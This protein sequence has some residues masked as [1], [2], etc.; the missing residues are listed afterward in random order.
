MKNT[1]IKYFKNWGFILFILLILEIF[2]IGF[3]NTN[4]L[5]ISNLLYS[6]NDFMHIVIVSIPFTLILVTGG[7]DISITSVMG[8]TSI[9]FGM[10][11]TFL[12]MPFFLAIILALL[13]ASLCGLINGFLVSNTD[14]N[15]PG[16][17]FR[18]YVSL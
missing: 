10:L 13:C 15:P 2:I 7:I 9:V 16:Y 1:I 3:V 4:F 6:S 18:N 14:I 12:N 8:L 17:N 11:H 5:N